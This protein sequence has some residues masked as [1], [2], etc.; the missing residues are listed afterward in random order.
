[1]HP[2]IAAAT[3]HLEEQ[4]EG[5]RKAVESVP[6]ALRNQ[7]PRAD[8]W[9]VAEILEHLYIVETGF[10]NAFAQTL[11]DGKAKGLRQDPETAPIPGEAFRTRLLDRSQRID[12][13]ARALPQGTLSADEAWQKLQ[14]SRAALFAVINEADGYA[15]QD[16]HRVHP[17]LGEQ[18]FYE[19]LILAGWHEARHA[20]QIREIRSV[21]ARH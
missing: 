7:R 14:Q 2:R 5:L 18:N 15:L 10:G 11:A 13:P 3:R 21:P 16:L 1:M 12:A 19:W 8:A 20:E 6:E 17:V 4:R 9:S